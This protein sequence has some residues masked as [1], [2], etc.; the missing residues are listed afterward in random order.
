MADIFLSY[1][2]ADRDRVA[3]LVEALE[4]DGFSVWWDRN[5]QPGPSFDREIE[6]AIDAAGC[7]VVVWSAASIESEWVRSEVE[8]G[9]RR[10]ILVPL[11]IDPVLPPLAHR[12]RQTADLSDWQGEQDGEY[13]R[14]ISGIRLVL[15]GTSIA[16]EGDPVAVGAVHS[17]PTVRRRARRGTSAPGVVGWAAFAAALAGIGSWLVFD[18]QSKSLVGGGEPVVHLELSLPPGAVIAR[19]IDTEVNITS[20]GQIVTYIAEEP[21]ERF[22]YYVRQLSDPKA[23]RLQ[24]DEAS[25]GSHWLTP[26]N[27]NLVFNDSAADM[28][29][30]VPLA[31]GAAS[32][33][34][35]TGNKVGSGGIRGLAFGPDGSL[36]VASGERGIRFLP[37]P[38]AAPQEVLEPPDGRF[39]GNPAFVRGGEA[40]L[41][42]DSDSA[43][44]GRTGSIKVFDRSSGEVRELTPGVRPKL[45]SSGHLVFLRNDSLWAASFDEEELSLLSDPVYVQGGLDPDAA[46]YAL[47]ENGTLV[48]VPALAEENRAQ[49]LVW[50]SREGAVEVVPILLE[51]MEQPAISPDGQRVLLH[52]TSPKEPEF[53]NIWIHS[54]ERGTTTKLTFD[55]RPLFSV[56]PTWLPSGDQYIFLR[57]SNPSSGNLYLADP[58]GARPPIEITD[59]QRARQ[60]SPSPNGEQLVLLLCDDGQQC[61]LGRL[62]INEPD[63][64]PEVLIETPFDERS[65]ELSPDGRWIAYVS[66][67]SGQFEVY[68]RPYPDMVSRRWQVS[69]DGGETPMWSKDGSQLFFAHRAT[70]D[71]MQVEITEGDDFNWSTPVPV[72]DLTPYAWNAG[73]RDSRSFDISVDGERFLMV[74]ESNAANR[75][76]VVLNWFSELERLVPTQD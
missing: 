58:D 19:G 52:G 2:S 10:G 71:L 44:S 13:E 55:E 8:E 48:Y 30:R 51:T 50:V 37:S 14:L 45:A 70:E 15:A 7:M 6:Q 57:P 66:D 26:D 65:P 1:S 72:L 67:E 25:I 4:A 20:D 29:R 40:I 43:A 46:S 23:R 33:V 47:A 35:P 62:L 64:Q 3:P 76:M 24:L 34:M 63:A 49:E 56:N 31:G 28:Y 75:L 54:I 32:E 39:F 27:K 11:L 68:V 16:T 36:A 42:E 18:N 21:G 5:I 9:V 60:P 53:L 69:S 74:R 61:D 22:S 17:M 73:P 59:G 41:F 38:G 12:R